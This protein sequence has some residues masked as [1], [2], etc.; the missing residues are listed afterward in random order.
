[1]TLS[2]VRLRGLCLTLLAPLACGARTSQTDSA[3][4]GSS[5]VAP[6]LGS[7]EAESTGGSSGGVEPG[8]GNGLIEDGEWCYE[9]VSATNEY[10]NR[11]L[12]V[13]RGFEGTRETFVLWSN[14]LVSIAPTGPSST[15]LD[16]RQYFEGSA[17]VYQST[18]HVFPAQIGPS[19]QKRADYVFWTPEPVTS[20][21]AS[22]CLSAFVLP[23]PEREHEN[24][25]L[26]LH[27]LDCARDGV[28]TPV[29]LGGALDG[30]FAVDESTGLGALYSTENLGDFSPFDVGVHLKIEAT[31]DGLPQCERYLARAG[32][33]S[34]T[35]IEEVFVLGQQCVGT[36]QPLLLAYRPDE[37]GFDLVER[38]IPVSFSGN[39]S[40]LA[41]VDLN[42]DQRDD[43]VLA[44]E[45]FVHALVQTNDGDFVSLELPSVDV[46]GF[47]PIETSSPPP[48]QPIV[49]VQAGTFDA[50]AGS[51]LV[52][53]VKD[54]VSVVS[55]SGEVLASEL[56]DQPV[57]GFAAADINSDTL[58]DLAILHPDGIT[59]LISAP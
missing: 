12:R 43:L 5:G 15:G 57:T 56:F 26:S 20:D 8:C 9:R 46:E 30:F 27:E 10:T 55:F 47:V 16:F 44:G 21:S 51:E 53:P 40:S 49:R 29:R 23:G 6:D 3:D 42:G 24:R 13:M 35:N 54:G 58:S 36:P 41:L 17:G 45:S 34:A 31:L 19:E 28:I 14:G 52:L 2:N 33:P 7:S 1:M 11:P 32:N 25:E 37:P 22:H 4:T 59:F 18:G 50:A 39:A 48:M 38:E